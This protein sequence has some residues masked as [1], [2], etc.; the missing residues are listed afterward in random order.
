MADKAVLTCL[1]SAHTGTVSLQ[2]FSLAVY[3]MEREVTEGYVTAGEK[4]K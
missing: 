3:F 1:V 2:A 4:T